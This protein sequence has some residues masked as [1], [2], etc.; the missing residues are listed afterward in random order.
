[1]SNEE[2]I[3]AWRDRE[4]WLSLSDEE[5]A[6]MPENPAGVVELVDAEM[7]LVAGGKTFPGDTCLSDCLSAYTAN[8]SPCCY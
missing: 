2:I 5:R 6:A 3:R 4:H 8:P 7:Q 1:M